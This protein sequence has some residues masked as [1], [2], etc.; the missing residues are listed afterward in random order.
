MLLHLLENASFGMAEFACQR[1]DLFWYHCTS[2]GPGNLAQHHDLTH[3]YLS[4]GSLALCN[5]RLKLSCWQPNSETNALVG[6]HIQ[7]LVLTAEGKDF[8]LLCSFPSTF[9]I[10]K[11]NGD[12]W[13]FPPLHIRWNLNFLVRFS[14]ILWNLLCIVLESLQHDY[15]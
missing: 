11:G 14:P 15:R 8:L 5:F 6:F 4:P 2:E 1:K 10:A 7:L 9:F 12:T 3:Q 13:L